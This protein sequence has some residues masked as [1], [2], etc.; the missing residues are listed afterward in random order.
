MKKLTSLTAA[1]ALTLAA[2]QPAEDPAKA[3]R[4]A[5]P[6]SAAIQ[7]GVPAAQG[8]ANALSVR[9]EAVS[10]VP[11]YQSEYAVTSYWTALTF[12][13][14][15]WWTLEL[16]QVITAFPPTTCG[17]AACTWGPWQSDDQLLFWK[18]HVEKVNGTYVY[19]L[20][21]QPASDRQAP[22][23]EL[24]GGTAVPGVDRDHGSG[25]LAIDFDAHDALP[26]PEG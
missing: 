17:E 18:L 11:S 20:S 7:V 22:F 8:T 5:L 23:V 6:K 26:H 3:Y 21:A 19:A 25:T 10:S 14:G 16:V 2:C 4:D 1:A 9:R 15:V 13:V 12:N 24:L